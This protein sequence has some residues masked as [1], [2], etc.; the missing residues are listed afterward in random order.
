[1]ALVNAVNPDV[2]E[3]Q[4]TMLR[5]GKETTA[6]TRESPPCQGEFTPPAH[7]LAPPPPPVSLPLLRAA[8]TIPSCR[9]TDYE[10]TNK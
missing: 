10:Q 4:F 9:R 7:P 6:G 2:K 5:F 1:M 8:S 3:P